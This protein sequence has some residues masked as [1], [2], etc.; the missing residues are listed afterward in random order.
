MDAVWIMP[1][2]DH[3]F[4]FEGQ[5]T[6]SPQFGSAEEWKERRFRPRQRVRFQEKFKAIS[7]SSLPSRRYEAVSRRSM[8]ARG[9][10]CQRNPMSHDRSPMSCA[11]SEGRKVGDLHLAGDGINPRSPE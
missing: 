4:T 6:G 11:P 5:R 3:E 10:V 8:G 9:T 2:V 7:I 1:R